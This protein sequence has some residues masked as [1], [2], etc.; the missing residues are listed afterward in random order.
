MKLAIALLSALLTVLPGSL[1]R[2]SE[3]DA[4]PQLKLTLADSITLALQKNRGV[5]KAR[6]TR[7]LEKLK[8]KVSKDEFRPKV[9]LSMDA[10]TGR[11]NG[12]STRSEQGRMKMML[13][14]PSGGNID[15]NMNSS[16]LRLEFTQPLL[17]GGGFEVNTASL[18]TAQRQEEKSRL[19]FKTAITDIVVQVIEA[20]WDFVS[21]SQRIGIA[22][23]SLWRAKDQL[24]VNRL[25]VRAGRMA[26]LDLI[27][28]EAQ[29][30]AQERLL[31]DARITL[32]DSRQKFTDL[33]NVD[34]QNE[35]TIT[36]TPDIRY[37]QPDLSQSMNLALQNSTGYSELLLS[38][39]DAKSALYQKE[40]NLKWDLSFYSFV[41]SP[42][43]TPGGNVDYG[44]KLTLSIPLTEDIQ[45]R[46]D[47]IS[48]QVNLQNASDD[49]REKRRSVRENAR[50]KVRNVENRFQQVELAQRARELEEQKLEVERE[51]MKMGLSS[52]FQLVEFE[53]N[54]VSSQISEVEAKINY[55]KATAELDYAL[56]TT[57]ATWGIDAAQ[58]EE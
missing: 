44:A 21:N 32:N 8:L 12:N 48:A 43:N 19:K 6:R 24:N 33:L 51:K 31:Q 26:K 5:V 22:T 55:L 45:K 7:S 39:E 16:S 49:L 56:G 53:Y 36:E 27:Q 37:L 25:L 30:A 28:S 1:G 18:K 52:S 50:V 47:L 46:H 42:H 20:Y 38:V 10:E 4:V 35:I 58:L 2:A 34:V 40:N 15:L 11:N 13:K 57:L 29:V 3:L 9:A 54:L 17:K 14:V 23:R 41:D